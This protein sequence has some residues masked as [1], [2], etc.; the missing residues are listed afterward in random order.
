MKGKIVQYLFSNNTPRSNYCGQKQ[1][2]IVGDMP[3]FV[4]YD[5]S[6]VWCHPE[7]FN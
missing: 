3:I 6:D 4:A 2:S 7:Y 1:I 5:S